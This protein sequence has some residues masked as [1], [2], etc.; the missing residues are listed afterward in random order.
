[1]HGAVT[2][3]RH[4]VPSAGASS[5]LGERGTMPRTFRTREVNRPALSPEGVN[6]RRFDGAALA[7]PRRWIEDDVRVNQSAS[8]A[9]EERFLSAG[10]IR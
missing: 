9:W 6:D 1:M 4:D 8:A 7:V 10:Q 5:P 3:H 2:T